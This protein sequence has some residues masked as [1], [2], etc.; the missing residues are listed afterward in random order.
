MI[1]APVV[2]AIRLMQMPW[3]ALTDTPASNKENDLMVSE[4]LEAIRE[5]QHAAI[6]AP[7]RFWFDFSQAA[8]TGHYSTLVDRTLKSSSA[9]L[10]KP[11]TSRVASNRRR[12]SKKR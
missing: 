3:L 5:F 12:L 9:R 4:K 8:T 6:M 2:I 11:Y 7:M 10:A 1:D